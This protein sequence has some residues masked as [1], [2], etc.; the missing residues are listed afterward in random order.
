M[1]TESGN[2]TYDA[3]GNDSPTSPYY[4]RRLHVPGRTSGLTIGRGYDMKEKRADKIARELIDAGVDESDGNIISK[5]SGLSGDA[6][7]DFIETYGLSDFEI[8]LE[9]QETLFKISYEEI[10]KDVNRICNKPD[11]VGAYG[12][13]NF[14]TLDKVYKDILVDLRFRGDYT[15]RS[16]RLIQKFIANNQL[17]AFKQAMRNRENWS[18]VPEDRFQRRVDF[19]NEF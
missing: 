15:G 6:A 16:R 4:S 10:S 3:E 12:A 5:A 2:L 9:T 7:K 11:C 19:V 13:I 14:Y 17:E 18:S 1:T 8:S